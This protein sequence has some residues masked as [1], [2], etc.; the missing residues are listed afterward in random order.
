MHRT[1]AKLWIFS[2]VLE[3]VADGGCQRGYGSGGRAAN[4]CR[5]GSGREGRRLLHCNLDY[6]NYG[7]SWYLASPVCPPA[8]REC[9]QLAYISFSGKTDLLKTYFRKQY[10][11]AFKLSQQMVS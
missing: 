10:L 4:A 8:A 1:R 11:L 7:L 6:T 5:K 3:L 2:R 9:N